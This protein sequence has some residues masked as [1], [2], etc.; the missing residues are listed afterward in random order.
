MARNRQRRLQ[1]I[2]DQVPGGFCR[3]LCQRYCGV[4]AFVPAEAERVRRSGLLPLPVVPSADEL[5]CPLLSADGRCNIYADRPLVCRLW[6]AVEDMT[7][8]HGCRPERLLT[9]AEAFGLMDELVRIDPGGK[10]LT[11]WSEM[12]A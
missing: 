7:C 5:T 10:L 8:P 4:I 9:R 2:Y 12:D 11:P 1:A 6:G 3:G